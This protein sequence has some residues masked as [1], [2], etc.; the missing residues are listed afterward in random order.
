MPGEDHTE[1]IELSNLNYVLGQLFGFARAR[2]EIDFAMSLA[3]EFRGS[4][5][6]G[7]NTAEEAQYAFKEGLDILNQRCDRAAIRNLLYRYLCISEASGLYE[8]IRN[9][10]GIIGSDIY[11]LWPFQDIVERHAPSG[12]IKAP[13]AN[14]IFRELSQRAEEVG[15]TQ[16]SGALAEVFDDDLR[17]A[18][19][20]ADFIIWEDGIRLRKRNGGHPYKLSWA[21]MNRIVRRGFCFVDL[22]NQ[23]VDEAIRSY[24]DSKEIVG[25]GSANKIPFRYTIEYSSDGGFSISTKSPGAET[26]PEFVRAEAIKSILGKRALV[27][28]SWS[29]DESLMKLEEHYHR[30]GIEPFIRL[31]PSQQEHMKFVCEL[32]SSHPN[33]FIEPVIEGGSK[34]IIF[35]PLGAIEAL[36][37]KLDVVLPLIPEF[38]IDTKKDSTQPK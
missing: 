10:I 26:S 34:P 19:A 9:Q 37:G 31:Y 13:N 25:R 22:L 8:I 28:V 20:H 11:K 30:A 3:P 18:I 35:T 16:L 17:N 1:F 6:A 38:T 15:L 24:K 21:Q 2:D 27:I 5:D 32:V 29:Q 14:R 23:Y 36:E 7:W 12:K 33:I 4:Q